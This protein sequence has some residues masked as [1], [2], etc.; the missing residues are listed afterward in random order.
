MMLILFVSSTRLKILCIT[1]FLYYDFLCY[2]I[3]TNLGSFSGLLVFVQNYFIAWLAIEGC[4]TASDQRAKEE[5]KKSKLQT[6]ENYQ[7]EGWYPLELPVEENDVESSEYEVERIKQL[8]RLPSEQV[9]KLEEKIEQNI[10]KEETKIKNMRE[11]Q[12]ELHFKLI[13]KVLEMSN[14]ATANL[15]LPISGVNPQIKDG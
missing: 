14:S 12:L 1:A 5:L 15:S 7:A 3:L 4:M 9:I 8:V 6:Q 11:K 13:M 10:E 2:D